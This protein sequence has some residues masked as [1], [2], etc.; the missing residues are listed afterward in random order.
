MKKILILLNLI[1]GLSSQLKAIAAEIL[2][3]C[4]FSGTRFICPISDSLEMRHPGPTILYRFVNNTDNQKPFTTTEKN[5]LRFR[6][7]SLNSR[8]S[9]IILREETKTEKRHRARKKQPFNGITI[10]RI[11]SLPEAARG[12]ARF[13]LHPRTLKLAGQTEKYVIQ[14]V[15]A[16]TT[17]TTFFINE[18][19]GYK[20]VMHEVGHALGLAHDDD[21][22]SLMNAD[23]CANTTVL[24]NGPVEFDLPHEF[25]QTHYNAINRLHQP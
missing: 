4:D 1:F 6:L 20:V 7:N 8:V 9:N 18:E 12:I 19:Y 16:E 17:N 21:R 3:P 24:K 25:N 10:R 15:S 2:R 14:S 13:T 23:L 11:I 5:E 22:D